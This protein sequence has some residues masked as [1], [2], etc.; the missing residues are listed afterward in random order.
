MPDS[1][2]KTF[3]DHLD[4]LRGSLL[5]S[6][7]AAAVAS[8]AAFCCKDFLFRV[9]LAPCDSRFVTYRLLARLTHHDVSFHANLVNIELTQQVMTH[10]K[11]AFGAGLLV[12]TPYI[13]YELL[14]FLSPALYRNERRYTTCAVV[15][16]YALFVVGL[17][18]SYYLIFPFT[19]RF[20]Y[21]YQV[22]ADVT[23]V[24]SLS[25]YVSTFGILGLM[26]GTTCELPLL[27]W[28]LAKLGLLQSAFMTRYRRHAVVAV[29]ALAAVVTPTADA[30][31]MLVVALPIYLLYEIS[32]LVVRRTER[33]DASQETK[34]NVTT[35]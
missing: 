32:I 8:I 6:I 7:V 35:A 28:L 34:R 25:S 10:L 31:T 13:I 21:S 22:R 15:W 4:D 11:V 12:V 33:R 30:F 23:N 18:M 2:K 29:L 14:R 20:L 24:V 9:V 27:G 19:F 17:L 16:G 1:E 3:W 26:M 5:R